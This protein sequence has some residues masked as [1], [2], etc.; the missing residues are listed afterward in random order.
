MDL[1]KAYDRVDRDALWQVLRLYGVGCKLLKA[2][3]R[4]Y[5]DCKSCVR[6]GNEISEWFSVNVGVRQGCHVTMVVQLVYGCG[7]EGSAGKNTW[8][9]STVGEEKWEES[10]LLFADDTVLVADSK[11]KFVRLVEEFGRVWRRRK[12]KVNLAKSKVMQ[13]ARDGFVKEMNIMMD[14]LIIIGGNI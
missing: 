10:L 14:G 6:I 11:K 1:E 5:V 12:L 7:S 9:R 8:K 3:K 4:F 2:V 13:S